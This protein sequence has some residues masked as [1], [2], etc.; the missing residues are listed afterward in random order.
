MRVL[1]IGDMHGCS[2]A[3]DLLWA[4]L[5]PQPD[6]LIIALGD[7][8]DR[9][10]DSRGV[11]QRLIDLGKTH[12]LIAL[13]GNHDQMMLDALRQP[14]KTAGWLCCGGDATIAS[15]SGRPGTE[16]LTDVPAEH[17][18]FLETACRDWFETDTH[19]FVH[20]NAYPD[21]ALAEQPANMLLWEKLEDPQPHFSGKIMIC[22]HTSQRSGT[23]LNLGHTICID[24][25]VYGDGWLTGLDVTSGQMWQA[26]QRGQVRMAHLDDFAAK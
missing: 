5:N 24:T 14:G 13:R 11:V 23:P 21:L 15:Y 8:V 6:D 19:L 22:G 3:F 10:P 25:W 4:A 20:A 18:R 9:G 26:S 7:Y 2:L 16:E 1:A 12:R 17:V